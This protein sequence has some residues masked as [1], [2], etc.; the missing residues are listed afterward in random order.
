MCGCVA[1][2][3]KIDDPHVDENWRFIARFIYNLAAILYINELLYG[4]NY[5]LFANGNGYLPVCLALCSLNVG[6]NY[7]VR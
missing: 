5:A 4:S 1:L 3:D 7:S 2:T 6:V